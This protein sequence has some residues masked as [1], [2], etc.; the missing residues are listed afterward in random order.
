MRASFSSRERATKVSHGGDIDIERGLPAI[1]ELFR[2]A[3]GLFA[4]AAIIAVLLGPGLPVERTPTS[5]SLPALA[6]A[7]VEDAASHRQ[8]RSSFTS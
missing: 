1:L 7:P 4:V 5:G 3:S 6:Q 8:E 2:A